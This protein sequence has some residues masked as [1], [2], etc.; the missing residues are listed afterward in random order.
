MSSDR[1]HLAIATELLSR[2]ASVNN[3]VLQLFFYSKA[4]SN[5]M[6]RRRTTK[7]K[8]R[9][10]TRAVANKK[11]WSRCCSSTKQTWTLRTRAASHRSISTRLLSSLWW[12]ACKNKTKFDFSHYLHRVSIYITMLQLSTWFSTSSN[13]HKIPSRRWA[14]Y[15]DVERICHWLWRANNDTAA[16]IRVVR[17]C[18]AA[19]LYGHTLCSGLNSTGHETILPTL[20]VKEPDSS[21]CAR[22]ISQSVLLCEPCIPL[23]YLAI[24]VNPSVLPASTSP[25]LWPRC[26]DWNRCASSSDWRWASDWAPSRRTTTRGPAHCPTRSWWS[27]RSGS[28]ASLDAC[29][30]RSVPTRP[31]WF[32]HFC[33]GSA[34]VLNGHS[35]RSNKTRRSRRRRMK[36]SCAAET[37]EKFQ[38]TRVKGWRTFLWF[39][40]ICAVLS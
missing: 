34:N 4:R 9:Y 18:P 25:R 14:N 7:V 20:A 12:T 26:W 3:Q 38:V 2:G 19:I 8:H 36:I 15:V 40:S 27:R 33:A 31:P 30:A 23:I 17:S 6:S 37:G 24:R 10:T 21:S 39:D 1:G 29:S 16:I 32:C 5:F 13:S 22:M 28:R 11:I 35:S